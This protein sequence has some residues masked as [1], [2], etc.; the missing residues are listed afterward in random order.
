MS[1][2]TMP[3]T[4]DGFTEFLVNDTRGIIGAM[5]GNHLHLDYE[6]FRMTTMYC[7]EHPY[8]FQ[9]S[10]QRAI[11]EN[12]EDR[13]LKSFLTELENDDEYINTLSIMAKKNHSDFRET[14][15]V[16]FLFMS[17]IWCTLFH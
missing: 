9:K 15:D 16:D 17:I 5:F 3:T 10:L 2:D 11:S 6:N 4:M 7:Y 13:Y 12:G 1:L 14:R 8:E